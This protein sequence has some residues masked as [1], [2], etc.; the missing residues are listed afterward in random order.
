MF[1]TR[2]SLDL[3][4]NP[5]TLALGRARAE[6]RAVLDLTESNP[7][8][9]GVPYDGRAIL[10]AIAAPASLR[11]EPSPF[12]LA[13]ARE[14]IAR[15]HAERGL[16]VDASRVVLTASTSEAYAFL[17]KLLAD[18]GDD[19]LVP[20]PSYPLFEHLAR[21]E[22]VRA[23]PYRLA[24]DGAWHIDVPALRA[25]VT[26]RT[27]AVVTV[28]PNNP[29]GSYLKRDELDALASLGLPILSDEVFAEFPLRDD[30]R[31]ARSALD[32]SDAR[33]VFVLG[34]L[35]KAAALPQA[36]LA[37]ILV[38]GSTSEV[39]GS[40]ARLELIADAFLSVGTAVQ[41][42]APRLMASRGMAAGFL[43]SRCR[44][45]L[46]CLRA[47]LELCPASVLDVEGGWYA[48]I[49]LPKTQGEEAW[50]LS[51]LEEEGVYLHPGYFFDIEDGAHAVVSLIA[52]ED[53]VREGAMRIARCI[54]RHTS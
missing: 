34:G 44:A 27:R 4:P 37:W 33:L 47:S 30:P 41:H 8:R 48:T 43:R 3:S 25:A 52:P 46:A 28:S 2:A 35:S 17:F 36:K 7:T 19:I 22:S 11:Y 51:L 29:T 14:A 45:N 53:I 38:G 20:S 24:Y 32:P 31:R 12:G 13:S 42:A 1:S 26:A 50:A 40:L 16:A 6:D 5:V 18:P 9:A 10:D 23:V 49:R 21:L 39:D 15:D 54:V